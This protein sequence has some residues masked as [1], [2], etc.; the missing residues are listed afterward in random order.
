[1]MEL[2]RNEDWDLM[3]AFKGSIEGDEFDGEINEEL[4]LLQASRCP[5]ALP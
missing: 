2:A 3:R 5:P 1:M 4:F